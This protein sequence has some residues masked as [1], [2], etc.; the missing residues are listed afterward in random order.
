[1]I[2]DGDVVVMYVRSEDNLADIMTKN[3]K[4]ALYIKLATRKEY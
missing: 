4:E 2:K 3:K 1:M